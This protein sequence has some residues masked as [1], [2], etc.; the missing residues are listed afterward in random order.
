MIMQDI[1]SKEK[2]EELPSAYGFSKSE[3]CE[4]K[5]SCAPSSMSSMP[6]ANAAALLFPIS[7]TTLAAA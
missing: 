4:S 2:T 3:S 5:L 6:K 7:C 1:S